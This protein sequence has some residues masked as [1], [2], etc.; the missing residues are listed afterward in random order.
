MN[1]YNKINE[2]CIKYREYKINCNFNSFNIER[3]KFFEL[4][5]GLINDKT[6]EEFD[7]FYKKHISYFKLKQKYYTKLANSEII[8]FDSFNNINDF[9][10][11]IC[12]PYISNIDFYKELN[13]IL[14]SYPIVYYINI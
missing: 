7:I 14:L 8:L 6:D 1:F 9:M 5:L 3:H 13:A 4:L 10:N 11:K 12:S 2:Q